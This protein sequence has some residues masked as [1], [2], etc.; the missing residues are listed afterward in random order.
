MKHA[1]L[2]AVVLCLCAP[3]ASAEVLDF[4][5]LTATD[6][7]TAMPS[8]YHGFEFP[9]WRQLPKASAVSWQIP[10]IDGEYAVMRDSFDPHSITST[11]DFYFD[12]VDLAPYSGGA[13][14]IRIRGLLDGQQQYNVTAVWTDTTRRTEFTQF[15]D[16]LVDT[17]VLHAWEDI[18]FQTFFMDNFQYHVPEPGA[19]SALA[20]S[21][22]L[23]LRRR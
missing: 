17:I 21:C 15:S 10:L 3:V 1:C 5:D 7:N 8:P 16:V 22:L 2:L 6:L 4:E 18:T 23:V 14:T 11:T 20:L 9:Q 19:L 13:A 12:G